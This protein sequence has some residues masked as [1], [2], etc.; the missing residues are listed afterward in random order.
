MRRSRLILCILGPAGL[1][2]AP[3]PARA[4][5]A[6]GLE[7]GPPAQ[8]EPAPTPQPA[9]QNRLHRLRWELNVGAALLP[10]DAYTKEVGGSAS[11][12]YHFNDLL[13][14][15]IAHGQAYYDWRSGLRSQLED[16][17]GYAPQRFP[18]L[19]YA[20]DTN[21]VISPV[22]A[23][24]ALLNGRL[25]YLHLFALVGVGAALVTGGE[26]EPGSLEPGRGLHV[27]A[28]VDAGLGVRAWLSQ[29]W[30][31]RYELRQYVSIDT[32]TREVSP[33]FYMSLTASV[34]WGGGK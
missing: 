20:L 9:I 11:L 25:L 34:T 15:E 31:L 21:L 27:A 12:T 18:V 13:G 3:D 2:L 10:S 6:D 24:L 33:P 14:W 32:A 16:N 26:P 23:K 7:L 1:L 17:F 30:S 8:Q 19:R 29:R 5:S 28:L 22:Y 4:A